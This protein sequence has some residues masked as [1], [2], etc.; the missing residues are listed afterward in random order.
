MSLA[1]TFEQGL[2]LHRAGDLVRAEEKFRKVLRI[3]SSH[4][5]TLHQMGFLEQQRGRIPE[6]TGFLERA[7]AAKPTNA[8][9]RGNLGSAYKLQGRVDDAITCYREAIR[10]QPGL[11]D[12][13]YNLG[14]TLDQAGDRAGAIRCYQQALAIQPGSVEA[15]NNL[16]NA[17]SLERRFD[18][19]ADC[20]AT[21]LRLRPGHAQAHMNLGINWL[22]AGRFAEAARELA[23]ATEL[24]PLEGTAWLQLGIA[25]LKLGANDESIAALTRA[26]ELLP[27]TALAWSR[28]GLTLIVAGRN[29]AAIDPL[30]RALALNPSDAEA[31]NLIGL[32]ESGLGRPALAVEH[33]RRSVA[34]APQGEAVWASL[35]T[36]LQS[37]ARH[38]EAIAAYDRA[39][40]LNPCSAETHYNR[41][42]SVRSLGRFTEALAGFDRAI[43]LRPDFAT[44]HLN[45]GTMLE[46]T[47]QPDEARAAFELAH[48]CDPN[49]ADPLTNLGLMAKAAGDLVA[50]TR[51][52]DESLA[53]KP[54]PLVRVFRDTLLPPIYDSA[55]Q[56]DS[57]R[58]D[59]SQRLDSLLAADLRLDPD[60]D[61]FP[62]TFYLPYQGCDD[63]GLHEQ[64]A[65]L[66]CQSTGR[67]FASTELDQTTGS[68]RSPRTSEQLRVGFISRFFYNH[69][70]ARLS[71]GLVRNLPRDRF[72]V[73][74]LA[75][76][77]DDDEMN[78][79]M[80]SAGDQYHAVPPDLVVAR[81]RIR[82]LELDVLF[83]TDIGM[84]PFT[85]SLAFTRLAP[86]Q[87]VTWGHPVT[88]GIPNIDWFVSS[89]LI[90]PDGAQSHYSERL[91]LLP[92]LPVSY[93]RPTLRAARRTRQELGLLGGDSPITDTTTLYVC[94][95]SL[96]KFHPDFDSLLRSILERDP[97][98]VVL[99]IA[100]K[101]QGW[102]D[103]LQRRF[104][105]TLG[106]VSNRIWFAPGRGQAEF[107]ELLAAC[108]VML[109]PL[110]FGGGNTSFEALAQGLPIITLPSAFM[111]GR[112]TL[113]CY[114][115]LGLTDCI[116]GTRDEYV[117]LAVRF[118]RDAVLRAQFRERLLGAGNRLFNNNA[119]VDDLASFLE[120]AARS[121]GDKTMSN[122]TSNSHRTAVSPEAAPTVLSL[123]LHGNSSVHP[124]ATGPVAS[125]LAAPKVVA[126]TLGDV[127]KTC[128]CPACGHHVA[129]P[130]YDGGQQPLTTL[131][132]PK[133]PAEAQSM[134][135]LPHDFLRCVDC[136]HVYNAQFRYDEVPYS[137]KPNLMFNKGIIWREHLAAV[138]DLIV[139][140]LPPRPVVVEIGCGEGHLLRG[141]AEKCGAGRFVGFD[142]NG[143]ID[144]G[145]GLIE[146]RRELF[147]PHRHLAELRPHLIVSRHVLEHLMNPL[148]FVQALGFAASWEGVPTK[149]LI[150][151]PCIDGVLDSG[152][153]VD[154]FYEHNSHFTSRSLERLLTRCAATVELVETGYHGEV[155]FGL[156]EFRHQNH[157]VKLAE[158]AERFRSRAERARRML[159]EDLSRLAI[160]GQRIAI[161][162]GTGKAAAFINQ[163]GLDAGRFP[164]VVDSDPDK[165]GTFV[166]GMG[167]EILFRDALKTNPVNVIVIATQWRAHDIALEIQREGITYEQLLIEHEGQ[168][169]DYLAGDHPY[170][171]PKLA[172]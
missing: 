150:E 71:E 76:G 65:R 12:A 158:E 59:F 156:A 5:D 99:C 92:H 50:A 80:R 95:Q 63:R 17:L 26:T 154:F 118:G 53:R 152:R 145:N 18:E 159:G 29:Q 81:D 151:V 16:G 140:K 172:A 124:P 47:G 70:I 138:R 122:Q 142:P 143:A 60:R 96:F 104:A 38:T 14:L 3:D 61:L 134:K 37:L 153:T 160:T 132:W 83:Y 97:N 167:Q 108:D 170:R 54:Q 125:T 130:F 82:Q 35:G 169:V 137:E 103:T 147:E 85:Y 106:S 32:A 113:G 114:R 13:H 57:T 68:Q 48:T 100:P 110:H 75:M 22:N 139:S 131:A 77:A 102:V 101:Q 126:P 90:E 19:S 34:L 86:V 6:A 141:V 74:V 166:P 121:A 144:D 165:A 51:Y 27:T 23:R 135:R 2:K 120:C 128:T 119:G 115:Q 25:R 87:C 149:L 146:A 123:S 111:R 72:E 39:L 44:A 42:N 163:N 73:H 31:W 20:F 89:E 7:V 162:G 88:T 24:A 94:P 56:I 133:S 109:D 33:F 46:A 79:R 93:D 9:F 28:L 55:Q 30:R 171:K 91:A 136:G 64:L 1:T 129:V 69:T 45:R 52:L 66:Y 161:W 112:V 41:A 105:Q 10:L 116:A 58:R 4:A 49:L 8:I 155:V 78:A 168:L 21:A 148:A 164:I 107:L 43:E 11:A 67:P 98:G 40:V 36:C 62:S 84:D 15:L 157:Q 127:L 117:D